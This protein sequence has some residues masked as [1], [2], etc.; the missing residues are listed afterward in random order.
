MTRRSP[1]VNLS[2]NVQP[3]EQQYALR[4]YD[5][6]VEMADATAEDE[7]DE[8]EVESELDAEEGSLNSSNSMF[9]DLLPY[10]GGRI[11]RT[12]S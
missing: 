9:D 1:S 7:D 6:D 4:S 8:E 2:F 5:D 3:D 11:C 12:G 10:R